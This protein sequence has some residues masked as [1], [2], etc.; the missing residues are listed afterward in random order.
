[1]AAISWTYP[2]DELI[3]LRRQRD[4]AVAATP[5]ASGLSVESLNFNYAISG[6]KP[7][8]RPLRAFDDGRQTYIEFSP[9]IAVER[10]FVRFEFTPDETLQRIDVSRGLI[11]L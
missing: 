2:H 9:A 6:D 3:A 11:A 4:A 5:I 7:A 8:W 1:M 10:W